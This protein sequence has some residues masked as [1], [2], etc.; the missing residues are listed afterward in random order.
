MAIERVQMLPRDA[1]SLKALHPS[2]PQRRVGRTYLKGTGA[3]GWPRIEFVVDSV[4]RG[5]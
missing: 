2:V 4:K 3:G 5:A 1:K